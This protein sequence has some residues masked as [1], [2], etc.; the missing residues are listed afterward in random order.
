M[1]LL[2]LKTERELLPH[3]RSALDAKSNRKRKLH[4]SVIFSI[5]RKAVRHAHSLQPQDPKAS[6]LL[7]FF[8]FCSAWFPAPSCSLD[9][10]MGN[11]WRYHD[12]FQPVLWASLIVKILGFPYQ[13]LFFSYM[14]K[15]AEFILR[16]FS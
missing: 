4:G 16:D 8:T 11:W 15:R 14:E 1:H 10:C 6:F 3:C 5:H 9:R 2:W 13:E 12:A 7:L